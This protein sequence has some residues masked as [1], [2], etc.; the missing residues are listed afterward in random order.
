MIG[1]FWHSIP[2]AY[3]KRMFGEHFNPRLFELID[4]HADHYHWDRV[5]NWSD[6]RNKGVTPTTDKAGGGHAHCGFMIYQG[7]NWPA[8]YQG[9]AFTANLHGRRINADRIEAHGN[10]FVAR[11]EPDFMN[12]GDLWFRGLS[13]VMA[14]M[15]GFLSSTGLM[16]VNAMKT[17]GCIATR[18]G[19]TKS[20]MAR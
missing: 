10:G 20:H 15:A 11:H 12:V 2:G 5:E 9:K 16:L 14:L 19:F 1:H 17:M 13:F 3:F 4:Q 6:I 18:V 7:D 8:D